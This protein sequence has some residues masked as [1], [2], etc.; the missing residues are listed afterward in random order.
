MYTGHKKKE[1]RVEIPSQSE[2][3]KEIIRKFKGN[4]NKWF[5]L[6][7]FGGAV[8]ILLLFFFFISTYINSKAYR[9]LGIM[10]VTLVMR[11]CLDFVTI[12]KR[13]YAINETAH[14]KQQLIGYYEI[15]K[16]VHFIMTPLLVATYIYGFA[17]LLSI[18]EQELLEEHYLYLLYSS[19]AV[20]TGLIVLTGKQLRTELKILKSL[21]ADDYF[22]VSEGIEK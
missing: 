14:Y 2:R 10:T 11:I 7:L 8:V 22:H 1:L 19:W 5:P 18:F 15:R 9:G 16:G 12:K 20:F 6:L 17:M 13:R 3:S 21:I 4:N